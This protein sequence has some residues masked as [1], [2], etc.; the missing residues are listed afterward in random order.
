[1]VALARVMLCGAIMNDGI[2][3][4]GAVDDVQGQTGTWML[5]A[6]KIVIK[7]WKWMFNA[8]TIQ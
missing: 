2:T 1:M 5:E 7:D 4:R 3:V 8:A 6:A